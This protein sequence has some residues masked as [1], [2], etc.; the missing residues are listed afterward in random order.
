[1][2]SKPKPIARVVIRDLETGKSKTFTV[3]KNAITSFKQ[4]QKKI[5]EVLK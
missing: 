2:G 4:I 3:Y 5:A 1:M